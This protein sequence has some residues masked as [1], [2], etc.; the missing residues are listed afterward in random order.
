MLDENAIVKELKAL[1]DLYQKNFQAIQNELIAQ[2]NREDKRHNQLME[3]LKQLEVM[4]EALATMVASMDKTTED[5]QQVTLAFI[6]M[7][8]EQEEMKQPD[9][10]IPA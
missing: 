10:R 7:L 3:A 2:S 8:E 5:L 4:R 1:A 9:N 6:N